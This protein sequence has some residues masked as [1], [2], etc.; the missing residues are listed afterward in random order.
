[1][2][3]YT[4][5]SSFA[6]DDI[7]EASHHNDEFNKL[8]ESHNNQTGHAHN[9]TP[10]EGPV[11]GLIGDP[12]KV[13][14][15]NKVVVDPDN[16]RIGLFINASGSSV[17]QAR[18]IDGAFLPTVTNDMDLGT[19]GVRWKDLYL[20]G[21]M[22]TANAVITG[23]SISGIT[24]LAIADGGTGSST[25]SGAR[26]NLGLSIG[27]D[28]QGYSA[29]LSEIATLAPTDSFFIVGNGSGWTAET[30][31]TVRASLGA[32]TVGSNIFTLTNPNAVR[33]LR[34]N[35]NNTVSALTAAELKG[36]IGAADVSGVVTSVSG[37]GSVNGLTL[38]GTVTSSG[39]LTLGGTLTGVNLGTAVTGTLPVA[40]GG[41]GSNT[42]AGARASLSL[43][44]LATLSSVSNDNWA[45]ADLSIANGGTGASDVI[46]ARAN[47]G[48][49]SIGTLNSISNA[50]WAGA[51][52]SIA[53]G[54]TGASDAATA[55]ANLGISDHVTGMFG[56]RLLAN[57][58]YQTLPGGLVIQWGRD[59]APANTST[60]PLA[61]PVPFP[62][63]CFVLTGSGQ[64]GNPSAQDG[65][66][67]GA[68]LIS[69]STYSVFNDDGGPV[70]VH[71]IAI[72]Y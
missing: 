12:G 20:S 32:S 11:I 70:E 61:F 42:A 51:D 18:V 41:T 57:K 45:G 44:T 52:L 2:T 9:G 16:N 6:T 4:R 23:G 10:G 64:S 60:A 36:E 37:T 47:L 49:G 13:I 30:G 35:A 26:V 59:T 24:D 28:V 25:A 55:R 63:A 50:N 22:Y 40:N 14:P 66:N 5:Q 33:F 7:V 19:T 34:L 31:G 46:T 71:W 68:T 17:E 38:T 1:M 53:N 62:N 15:L 29:R 21:G 8:A 54:G 69:N 48:V 39:S 27:T 65:N 67:N 43:G 3:G 56:S 58:G 72:G